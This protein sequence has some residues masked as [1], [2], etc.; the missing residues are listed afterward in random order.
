MRSKRKTSVDQRYEAEAELNNIN[1]E[2]MSPAAKRNS[3]SLRKTP[4]PRQLEPLLTT[5]APRL[6]NDLLQAPD[7]TV[8]ESLQTIRKSK[9][10]KKKKKRKAA[11]SEVPFP[12]DPFDAAMIQ[13]AE[14]EPTESV[15]STKKVTKK[16]A[17]PLHEG[18]AAGGGPMQ[19]DMAALIKL[20]EESK[21]PINLNI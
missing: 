8:E 11:D 17:M 3:Q 19:L 6:S 14:P 10:K 2:M 15:A 21:V 4:A 13:A 20:Q 1:A 9:G 7:Q 18:A 5:S 16:T 12:E